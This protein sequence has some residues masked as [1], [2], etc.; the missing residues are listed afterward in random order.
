M[1]LFE[2][3]RYLQSYEA[4]SSNANGDIVFYDKNYG[5]LMERKRLIGTTTSYFPGSWRNESRQTP[6]PGTCNKGGEAMLCCFRE[7]EEKTRSAHKN[8][9]IF[10]YASMQGCAIFIQIKA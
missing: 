5:S 1:L 6:S 7:E 9:F 10:E 3:K 2:H 8:L 4:E